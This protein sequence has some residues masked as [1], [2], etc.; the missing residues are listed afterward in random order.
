MGAAQK[1]PSA[2]DPPGF[3]KTLLNSSMRVFNL[4]VRL[5]PSRGH[6]YTIVLNEGTNPPRPYS[7]PQVHRKASP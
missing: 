6:E 3:V 2:S 4:P 7:Y 1:V 5:P